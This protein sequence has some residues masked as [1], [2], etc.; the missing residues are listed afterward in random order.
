[1]NIKKIITTSILALNIVPT[2]G[3]MNIPTA[4]VADFSRNSVYH[5]VRNREISVPVYIGNVRCPNNTIS[6]NQLAEIHQLVTGEISSIV[7][8]YGFR[9]Y[10]AVSVDWLNIINNKTCNGRLSSF[11]DLYLTT[12]EILH[13]S[14]KTCPKGRTN[15]GVIFSSGLIGDLNRQDEISFE[16]LKSALSQALKREI[17]NCL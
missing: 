14:T 13:C 10:E 7:P 2:I 12:A 11:Y 8:H 1:M 4:T 15:F 3:A 17:V 5:S 9:Y 16:E 6:H